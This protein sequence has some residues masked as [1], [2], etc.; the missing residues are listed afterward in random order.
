MCEVTTLR[1]LII[2]A[3][4]AFI[5]MATAH[6]AASADATVRV[7]VHPQVKGNQ[8]PRAILASIF[9]KQAR[10]WGDG[11]PVVPVDQSVR[12]DVRRVFS[13]RLLDKQL[14]DVQIY[15][16]RKMTAGVVPPQVKTS[17]DEVIAFVASTPGAIGYVSAGAAVPQSVK[18]IEVVN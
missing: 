6:S 1:R 3:V 15:W 8:V 12:S 13:T 9:L 14:M 4:A 7:I 2:P 10:F 17:D 11:S 18:T 16:Q 5:L